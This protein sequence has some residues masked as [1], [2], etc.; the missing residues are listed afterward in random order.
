MFGGLTV[1]Q[2]QELRLVLA[3]RLLLIGLATEAGRDREAQGFEEPVRP[4]RFLSLFC[5]LQLDQL[6]VRETV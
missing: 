6:E 4:A 5:F 3:E 1:G 2:G